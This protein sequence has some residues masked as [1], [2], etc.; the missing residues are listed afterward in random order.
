M[1]E[2]RNRSFP[3]GRDSPAPPENS[4]LRIESPGTFRYAVL[5]AS[6][7]YPG[8]AWSI[9]PLNGKAFLAP[10]RSIGPPRACLCTSATARLPRFRAHVV[11][12]ACGSV[13]GRGLRAKPPQHRCLT[14]SRSHSLQPCCPGQRLRLNRRARLAY[15]LLCRFLQQVSQEL[16]N[17]S[18][19]T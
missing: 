10:V 11:P 4:R 7:L 19:V 5:H 9:A 3:D 18:A 14:P 1:G 16:R 17:L 15:V 2:G 13:S 6:S 12:S 8:C